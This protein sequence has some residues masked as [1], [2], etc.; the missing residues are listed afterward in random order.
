MKPSERLLKMLQEAD[1]EIPEG[2]RLERAEGAYQGENRTQGASVWRMVHADGLPV[3]KDSK[4][5]PTTV[6]SQW[7]MTQLVRLGIQVSDRDRHG[8]IYID[9]PDGSG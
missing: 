8:D 6:S 3:T 2:A 9:P 4:G 7:P 1:L 5:R